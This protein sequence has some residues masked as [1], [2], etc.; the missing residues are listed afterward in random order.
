[1]ST[2]GLTGL[3]VRGGAGGGDLLSGTTIGAGR[4][5]GGM[6]ALW[7]GAFA[8]ACGGEVSISGDSRVVWG[9]E[10]V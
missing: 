10:R 6:G 1:M 4:E 5:G 2:P 8:G 7:G 3:G 9:L